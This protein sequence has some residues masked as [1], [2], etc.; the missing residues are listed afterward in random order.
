MLGLK[1]NHVSKNGPRS[2]NPKTSMYKTCSPSWHNNEYSWN[3]I[4]ENYKV[5]RYLSWTINSLTCRC[6]G[7]AEST[8]LVHHYLL[9]VLGLYS[10]N[11]GMSYRKI[12]W[13]LEAARLGWRF[14]QSLWNLRG[15]WATELPRCLSNCQSD[16]TI[17]PS[18]L[19]TSRLLEI[20]R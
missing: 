19:T 16:A 3:K 8:T 17:I 4:S 13:R 7:H 5:L 18:I 2:Q 1:L 9:F 10:L 14:V 15:T 6:G 20:L 11:G 12:S